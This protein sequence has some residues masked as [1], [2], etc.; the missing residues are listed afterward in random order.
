M[1][2]GH[3]ESSLLKRTERKVEEAGKDYTYYLGKGG[4]KE[5]SKKAYNL[6]TAYSGFYGL[7]KAREDL[8][9]DRQINQAKARLRSPDPDMGGNAQALEEIKER[10]EE[11]NYE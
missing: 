2:L 6:L 11:V 8:P 1:K 9:A 5:E 7:L 10:L 3:K 4:D